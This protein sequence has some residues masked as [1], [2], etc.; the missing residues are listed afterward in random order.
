RALRDREG[1]G[2]VFALNGSEDASLPIRRAGF[3]VTMLDGATGLQAQIDHHRPDL[4]LLDGREGPGRAELERLKQNVPVTAV[5]DDGHA[6]RLA[7]DYAYYPAVPGALALEWT[8]ASTLPRIGWEWA[9][10]GLNPA[11]AR[12]RVPGPRPT[13]LVSMGGSDPRALTLRVAKALTI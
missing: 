3:E 10:L 13:V 8:G 11:L 7:C 6:R 5:I 1:I 4:L 9:I 2:A 12:K